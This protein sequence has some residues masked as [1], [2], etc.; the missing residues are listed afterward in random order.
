MSGRI[1]RA[2][3]K[4]AMAGLGSHQREWAAAMRAKFDIRAE[5]GDDLPFALGC[6]V[7]A[8]KELPRHHEGRLALSR[9]TFSLGL[10]LPASAC[11]GHAAGGP[12]GRISLGR[13]A[14]C[15]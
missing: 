13:A 3:M 7:T 12:V 9:Y 15:R 1:A 10:L 5:T 11:C 2:A 6:L 14:L 8:A 4:L